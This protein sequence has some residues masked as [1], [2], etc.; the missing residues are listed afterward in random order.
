MGV[1][2]Q[3]DLGHSLLLGQPLVH[4]SLDGVAQI[5]VVGELA[6]DSPSVAHRAV[7]EDHGLEG[8]LHQ[9][10]ERHVEVVEV[11][12]REVPVADPVVA[13]EIDREEHARIGD[14][15]H[16]QVVRVARSQ[17]MQLDRAPAE[18][19]GH[20]VREG[21]V[22]GRQVG[23]AARR[24]DGEG[25]LLRDDR[26]VGAERL[27]QHGGSRGVV[28]VA[29]AVDDGRERFVRGRRANGGHKPGR[30]VRR[31]GIEGDNARVRVDEECIVRAGVEL[32]DAV[33]DL[34]MGDL[35]ALVRRGGRVAGRIVGWRRARQGGEGQ[36]E[37]G[38]Q[39][40][41]VVDHGFPV[42]S[43]VSTCAAAASAVPSRLYPPSNKDTRRPSQQ[44]SA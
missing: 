27:P 20:V 30:R 39:D 38:A 5:R 22:G 41:R 16:Q 42:S 17:V 7:A 12:P 40:A 14:E 9:P 10:V 26:H 21:E 19:Q 28:G 3:T 33:G 8:D 43:S 24:D 6:L 32:V 37:G 13:D 36:S 44:L 23:V 1:V 4:R 31:D 35:D 2:V 25:V 11:P 34:G 15:R 29:V 18:P